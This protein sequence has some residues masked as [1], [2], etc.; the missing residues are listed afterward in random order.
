M[1]WLKENWKFVA[2]IL[3]IALAFAGIKFT[4]R[5]DPNATQPEIIVVIPGGEDAAPPV[6][7][8]AGPRGFDRNFFP[9]ARVHAAREL[10]KRDG[11]GFV[12]AFSKIRKITDA[13][14]AAAAI[15]AGVPVGELGDG[16]LLKR[17]VE[18]FM[19]PANQEK[20][21]QLIEFLI[22]MAKLFAVEFP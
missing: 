8:A 7:G 22:E 14:I 1:T 5:T 18:W 19:D 10:A 11:T 20:I 21:K 2:T 6:V 13:D 15:Q 12:K 9:L 4:T 16:T 3:T 17:I